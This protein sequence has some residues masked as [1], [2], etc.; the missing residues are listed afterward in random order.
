MFNLGDLVQ[1]KGDAWMWPPSDNN[2]VFEGELAVVL[3]H[4][5]KFE[6]EPKTTRVLIHSSQK[7][8]YISNVGL[9]L[10]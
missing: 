3:T 1:L 10:F 9:R 8:G 5:N 2:H 7:I 6:F 4:E